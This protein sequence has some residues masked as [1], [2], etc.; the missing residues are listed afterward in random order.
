[1]LSL[2]VRLK[3][4]LV[5]RGVTRQEFA[6]ING[7]SDCALSLFLQNKLRS[8]RIENAIKN[9]VKKGFEILFIEYKRINPKL[10]IN[11]PGGFR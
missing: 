3:V 11:F 6:R 8:R 10:K 7:F 4:S 1:M 2:K 5:V 9:E